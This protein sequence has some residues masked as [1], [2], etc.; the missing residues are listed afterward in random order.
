MELTAWGWSST[1]KGDAENTA[2]QRL[3]ALIARVRQGTEL[4]RGY[5]YGARAM[6]EEIMQ[7]LRAA[8]G[9]LAGVVTRNGYGAL[10]LNTVRTMFVDVDL[11]PQPGGLRRLFGG[12]SAAG[13]AE[14]LA[15]LRAAL[16]A[17]SI[18]SFRIYRT[19]AGFRVTRTRCENCRALAVTRPPRLPA[20]RL[21]SACRWWTATWRACWRGFFASERM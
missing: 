7:E 18:G 12:K 13:E 17:H 19:A 1:G 4:P 9:G 21:T 20:L 10:V 2:R 11:P 8:D 15:R 6:R 14:T 5:D 3:G 16:A